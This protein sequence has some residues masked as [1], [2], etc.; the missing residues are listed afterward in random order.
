MIYYVEDDG[1]IRQLVVYT[2]NNSG[3]E[4]VGFEDGAG[5]FAALKE[6]KPELILLD[7]MLPGEDGISIL[8]HLRADGQTAGIPVIILTAKN[9]EYDKVVGLD[10]G[11]DDYVTKPFGMMELLS[12][13]RAVL[14]RSGAGSVAAS[15]KIRI[16][17]ILLDDEAH[18]VFVLEKRVD[19]T[20]KEYQLLK[21]LMENKNKV[22]T[23]DIILEKVW[24]YNFDGETRTAD[25][26]VRTLRAKLGQ[27]GN[28]IETVRGVGYR[29]GETV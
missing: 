5:L 4:A 13:I 28:L 23:R 17:G 8:K 10:Q 9:G 15:S 21:L 25:V 20:L 24:G 27:E 29:I 26:H 18:E 6:E 14:R 1:G 3:F 7:L 19:L 16:G 2:L 22:L 11:A 12:R